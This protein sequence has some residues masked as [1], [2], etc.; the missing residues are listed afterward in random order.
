MNDQLIDQAKREERVNVSFS[1]VELAI[2]HR[3]ALELGFNRPETIR[4]MVRE[5]NTIVPYFLESRKEFEEYR[6]KLEKSRDRLEHILETA[7]KNQT[8]A[9]SDARAVE[10]QCRLLQ[11]ELDAVYRALNVLDK[12]NRERFEKERERILSG[13]GGEMVSV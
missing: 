7:L 10:E 8:E 5:Y 11:K 9:F 3:K 12:E 1:S 13:T 4:Y 2:V 6:N